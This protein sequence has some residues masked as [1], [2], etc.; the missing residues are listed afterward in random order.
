LTYFSEDDNQSPTEPIPN[1]VSGPVA[2][3]NTISDNLSATR[4][5]CGALIMPTVSSIVGR[6]FFNSISNN[7]QRVLVGGFAFVAAK[8]ALK[9]YFKQKQFTRRQKRVIVDYTPE[10]IRHFTHGRTNIGGER[11]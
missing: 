8:G 6:L 4:I 2:V 11:R 3:Q 5:L 10:N 9:I 7:F 1:A